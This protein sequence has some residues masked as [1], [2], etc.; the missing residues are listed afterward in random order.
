MVSLVTQENSVALDGVRYRITGDVLSELISQVPEKVTIGPTST[1]DLKNRN[2]A[3]WN[4][5]IIWNDFHNG[6]GL[7]D[8]ADFEEDMDHAFWSYAGLRQKGHTTL[9]PLATATAV[10]ADSPT[11][12]STLN[13]LTNNVYG[14]FDGNVVKKYTQGSDS[15]GTTL[16][17]LPAAATDSINV[18][19]GGTEYLVWATT[20]GYSYSADPSSSV[21]DDTKNA[22]FLAF[23]DNRLWGIDNTGQLWW[24][25]VIGTEFDDAQLPLPDGS[26]K[27]LFVGRGTNQGR[28]VLYASTNIGLFVHD[29]DSNSFELVDPA[30][31]SHPD[32][33]LGFVRHMGSTY[34]SAGLGVFQFTNQPSQANVSVM[35]L[36]RKGGLIADHVGTII[37]LT[38]SNNEVIALVNDATNEPAIYSWKDESWQT[39]WDAKAGST[40]VDTMLVANADSLYR[41]YWS[42]AGR[43]YYIT[44]DRDVTNPLEL[45]TYKFAP[46]GEVITPWLNGKEISDGKLALELFVHAINATAAE[47]IV[48]AY[49][50]DDSGSFV[51]LGTISS[52]G[53]TTYTLG[54]TAGVGF[55]FQRIRFRFTFANSTNTNTPDLGQVEFHWIRPLDVKWRH[56][57]NVKWESS[58]EFGHA[59]EAQLD[60]L[61]NAAGSTLLLDFVFRN[62]VLDDDGTANPYNYYVR[63]KACRIIQKTG[64]VWD[65]T[66]QMTVEEL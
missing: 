47:T 9:P 61:I 43:I 25:K 27:G 60:L 45:S 52:I 37:Q 66:V 2:T 8:I 3:I 42:L 33:G 11:S 35:G 10:A 29:A 31:P 1:R 20:G 63:V 21:T 62:R 55:T 19:M 23:W 53:V 32:N 39:L 51:N 34:Y 65:G 64:E 30:V 54:A 17:T 4:D 26:V 12:C 16:D 28:L 40:T 6:N 18:R 41:L 13:I 50:I 49:E 7:R 5:T 44:L 59:P 24:S 57:F 22:K 58:P 46:T 56:T 15:W 48:V 14:T 36:D 38:A